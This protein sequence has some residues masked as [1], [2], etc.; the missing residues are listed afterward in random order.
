MTRTR[1]YVFW[2]CVVAA[3]GTLALLAG[4]GGDDDEEAA[5]TTTAAAAGAAIDQGR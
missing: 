4:C 1:R 3:V 5:G 2:A